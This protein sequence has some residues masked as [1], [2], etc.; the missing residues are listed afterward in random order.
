MRSGCDGGLA[1]GLKE[2]V[3]T[4]QKT[5]GAMLSSTRRT[6]LTAIV[7]ASL[8]GLGAMA[9]SAFTGA[10]AL[11]APAA[12]QKTR[13]DQISAVTVPKSVSENG[14]VGGDSMTVT[15]FF[16][17]PTPATTTVTLKNFNPAVASFPAEIVA[18]KGTKTATFTVTTSPVS[19]PTTDTIVA[20]DTNNPAFE[21]GV[22]F[23]VEP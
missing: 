22:Q 3:N 21:T 8:L 10:T 13:G 4:P 20:N 5:G 23:T 14:I 16:S 6:A 11:A 18:P 2:L 19:S 7:A 1:P 17:V 15:I 12:A 9:A